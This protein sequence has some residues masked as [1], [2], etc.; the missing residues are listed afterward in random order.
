MEAIEAAARAARAHDVV[1]ALPEGQATVIGDQGVKLSDG[2]KQRI[3]LA[4]ALLK[5]PAILIMD[6]ATYWKETNG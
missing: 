2:Q 5:D 1:A 4:R 3:A 6:E